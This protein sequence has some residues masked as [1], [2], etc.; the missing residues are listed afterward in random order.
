[1]AEG[2]GTTNIK[3]TIKTPKDKKDIEIGLD[4]SVKEASSSYRFLCI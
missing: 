4:A 2:N 1:M 3:L